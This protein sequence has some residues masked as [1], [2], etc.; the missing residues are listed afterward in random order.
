M[1]RRVASSRV[2]RLFS[3]LFSAKAS[4]Q[5]TGTGRLGAKRKR[6]NKNAESRVRDAIASGIEGAVVEVHC[7]AGVVDVVTPDEIIEVKRAK[8]WKAAMG[9]VLAYAVDFPGKKPRV[10]LFGSGAENCMLAAVTCE[11]FGV[12]LTVEDEN[13]KEVAILKKNQFL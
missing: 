12:R 1:C 11:R 2:M 13:G 9:Q 5:A 4:P 7:S 6:K 10:H 3:R 8:M